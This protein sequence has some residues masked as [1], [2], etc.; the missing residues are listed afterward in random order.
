MFGGR[1]VKNESGQATILIGMMML[2][3]VLFFAFVVNTGMLVNAKINLQNAAD[4]A[5][6]SGA[7]T[8][9]RLLNQISYLN[10]EMRRAYKKFLFRYYVV[11]NMAQKSHPGNP[12]ASTTGPRV[13]SPDGTA[14]NDNLVP[15]VCVIFNRADN[16]CQVE[17][18]ASIRIPTGN[19]PLDGIQ[20]TVIG[21]LEAIE[22]IRQ[23]NCRVNSATNQMLLSFWLFNTD[24]DLKD[25]EAQAANNNNGNADQQ[26]LAASLSVVRGLAFGLGLVPRLAL[27]RARIKTLNAYVNETAKPDVTVGTT[28][29]FANSPDPA[30]HERT[31]QAYLS[32]VNTLGS[33]IFASDDIQLTELLPGGG[34]AATL[35]KL[36]DIVTSFD[37]YATQFQLNPNASGNPLEK[38]CKS[39][40]VPFP[41]EN[42]FTVGV[43]KD[44]SVMTYYAVKLQAKAKVLF[45]PFGD[46]TMKAYAVAQ[47]FGS[48]IGPALTADDYRVRRSNGSV[49]GGVAGSLFGCTGFIPNLPVTA[50]DTT[51]QGWL[52]NNIVGAAFNQFRAL[53]GQGGQ[54][55]QLP[56]TL[57]PSDFEKAYQAAMVPNPWESGRYN[58]PNDQTADPFIQHFETNDRIYAFW[59]PIISPANPNAGDPGQEIRTLISDVISAKVFNR[60]DPNSNLGQSS[61]MADAIQRIM[62]GGLTNYIN[63]LGQGR[64]EDGEGMNVARLVDPYRYRPAP[65]GSGL[66]PP[67]NLSDPGMMLT[68]PAKIRTSWNEI[69]DGSYRDRG[70]NGY[71]VKFVSFASILGN[72]GVFTDGQ[73][74]VMGNPPRL[75][76]ES[77]ADLEGGAL[78]H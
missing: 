50:T 73:A 17:T 47:P 61:G 70:R 74:A 72:T 54:P 45:S 4:A 26:K 20:S 6:Y 66:P 43:K 30:Q 23:D 68:D 59:A 51:S 39:F 34:S 10:Y 62:L 25:V 18:L 71:S 22:R 52:L 76:P 27:L 53:A 64:G 19:G 77:S 69:K 28:N 41:F 78:Q 44:L 55:G 37:A 65:L 42:G 57:Q 15:S 46:M 31:I 12:G 11:G 24:P 7:A 16:F 48:R 32:A 1:R 33:G 9:A 56:S 49:C 8:Q 21:Q 2:T 63:L 38:A 67:V 13:W 14:Q 3:F 58:I 35:L 29:G 5:A 36:D 75:D 40:L 60:S